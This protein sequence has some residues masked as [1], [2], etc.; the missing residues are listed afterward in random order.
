MSSTAVK[1]Q[2]TLTVKKKLAAVL[3]MVASRDVEEKRSALCEGCTGVTKSKVDCRPCP[4]VVD[5]GVAKTV[6]WEEVVA[7]QDLLVSDRQL[8]GVT[9]HYMT[10]RAPVMST[11]MVGG[12]EEKLP[13]FVADMEEPCL[14]GLDP[15]FRVQRVW[16]PEECR[17]RRHCETPERQAAVSSCGGEV[18]DVTGIAH[19]RQ[20]AASNDGR[21]VDGDAGEATPALSPHAVD[22]EVSS[23]TKLTPEQVVKLEKQLME[24]EDIF[25]RDA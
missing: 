5:T 20:A 23:P 24:H 13:V 16:T 7:V 6:V 9:G 11:I 4:E 19:G 10:P 14:L 22:W 15:W 3:V 2:R 1:K 21:E 12:V 18:A 25:S 8:Y 17:C